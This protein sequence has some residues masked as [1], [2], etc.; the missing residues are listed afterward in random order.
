MTARLEVMRSGSGAVALGRRMKMMEGEK[1]MRR[2]IF[3][4]PLVPG[5]A[6]ARD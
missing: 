5:E 6:T 4:G 1:K 2:Y 3:G